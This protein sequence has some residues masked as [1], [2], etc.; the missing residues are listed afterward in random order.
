MRISI[1]QIMLLSLA[2]TFAIVLVA[3]SDQR[4]PSNRELNDPNHRMPAGNS[5]FVAPT[6]TGPNGST[7]HMGA[8]GNYFPNTTPMPTSPTGPTGPNNT[9]Q[10]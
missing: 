2:I 3:Q 5:G 8:T 4:N 9:R 6:G 10:N 7:G 1:L